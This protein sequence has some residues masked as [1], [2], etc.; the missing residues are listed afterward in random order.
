MPVYVA[1]MH[2]SG[3]SMVTKLLHLCGVY[4]GPESD[5]L[6][7]S[8]YNIDGFW[9]NIKFIEINEGILN[10]LGGG[11]DCPPSLPEKWQEREGFADLRLKALA[12]I[13]ELSKQEPWGWKDPRNSLTLPFWQDFFNDMKVVICLRNPLEVGSSL[14]QRGF[15]SWTQALELWKVYNQRIL[16]SAKPDQRIITHY[17]AYFG[18]PRAE[19]GR[20]L[21]FTNIAVSAE[22][23]NR[24]ISTAN[25]NLRHRRFSAPHLIEAG[26]PADVIDLYRQLCEEAGWSDDPADHVQGAVKRIFD[27]KPSTKAGTDQPEPKGSDGRDKKVAAEPEQALVQLNQP[28]TEVYAIRRDLELEAA[29]SDLQN[30]NCTVLELERTLDEQSSSIMCKAEELEQQTAL[31]CERNSLISELQLQLASQQS[32]AEAVEQEREM[33]RQVITQQSEQMTALANRVELVL[34]RQEGLQEKLA[35]A[36]RDRGEL[37]EMLLDANR[38]RDHLWRQNEDIHAAL[39]ELQA[40]LSAIPRNTSGHEVDQQDEAQGRA[41]S[42]RQLVR[43]I[44]EVARASL[45]TNATVIVAAKGDN[46]LLK[47]YGRRAWHFPQTEDGVY[48]GHHPVNSA[49]AIAH[50]E[51]LRAKGGDYLLLP[52]TMLWWLDHYAEFRLYLESHYRLLVRREDTCLIFALR[53]AAV[54]RHTTWQTQL[55]EMVAAFQRQFDQDPAILDWNTGLDLAARL[56][57]CAIFSPPTKD[58]VL[59]YMDESVDVVAIPSSDFVSL[60]EARRVA[61]AA[62]IR[63]SDD[64]NGS[65]DGAELEID[66]K[67]KATSTETLTASIII[68]CYNN[69]AQTETCL[70]AVRDTLPQNFKGE[71]IVV[72]DAS[73]DKTPDLLNR[74]AN[75]DER[76]KILSNRKAGGF[77]AAC[78]RGAKAAAG[79]ILVFLSSASLPMAGWLPPLLRIFREYANAGAVG[80]KHMYSDGRLRE[81]GGVVFSNGSIGGFGDLDFDV[82]APL[83][84]FVR[85][86]DY[87]SGTLLAT[88]RSLFQGLKGF[89]ADFESLAYGAAD[90]G[91]KV[92]QKNCH[93]YYQPESAIVDLQNYASSTDSFQEGN[94]YQ[95]ASRE[96]FVTRWAEALKQQP[97]FPHG[98]DSAMWQSLAAQYELRGMATR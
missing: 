6:P 70:A 26:V 28:S 67:S 16:E 79:E 30:L 77:L 31:V 91:F 72:N 34:D 50:L 85:E 95:A 87:C 82:D 52:N 98:F 93:V 75:S 60:T 12:A 27:S 20:L 73:T 2:R 80:G 25:T 39:Y 64:R 53:G 65:E 38:E 44:R 55:K 71:I 8:S 36:N 84:N 40:S 54:T 42:Y 1:G 11:W 59:P 46:E 14:R 43:Q 45:P 15:P 48:A 32:K 41:A 78:N 17:D 88:K 83:Y 94:G 47:L 63:F 24:Y 51:A 92:R 56:P 7:S 21:E 49:A 76:L 89:A 9:E 13:E 22:V 68:P 57:H 10:E 90:Y 19:L 96:R 74:L 3:T 29:L 61:K 86:V 35:E 18:R 4:L 37:R 5:L 33:L 66:W 62:V 97:S 58:R 23:I 81:A 69:L